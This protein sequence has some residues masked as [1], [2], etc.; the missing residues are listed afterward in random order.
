MDQTQVSR[1]AGEFFNIWASVWIT[2]NSGKILQEMEIPDHFTFLWETCKQVK[3]Q[4]LEPDMEQ[5]TVSNLE[6]GISRVYIV[7]LLI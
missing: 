4:Q 6:R 5:Q 2:T 1:I 7:M 3:K